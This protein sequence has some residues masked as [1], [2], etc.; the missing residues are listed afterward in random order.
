MSEINSLITQLW[1]TREVRS[2]KPNPIDEVKSLIY[3]LDILYKDV[4]Q[5]IVDDEEIT[6]KANNFELKFGS[7]VGADKDGNP[8]VTTVCVWG[9]ANGQKRKFS[10]FRTKPTV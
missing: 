9:L 10:C 3:Y 8:Y 1:Y 7:W 2:T 6:N 4:Y 5:K